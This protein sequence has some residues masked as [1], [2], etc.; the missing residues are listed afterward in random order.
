MEVGPGIT[1]PV[2]LIYGRQDK[3]VNPRAAFRSTKEFPM[4]AS[5]WCPTGHVTQMEHPHIVE[6]AWR[7]LVG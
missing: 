1:A 2:L 7:E 3:L 6:Q 4:Q 5:W